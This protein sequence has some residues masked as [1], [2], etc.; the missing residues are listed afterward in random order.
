MTLFEYWQL[1]EANTYLKKG[2]GIFSK[3]CSGFLKS[4]LKNNMPMAEMPLRK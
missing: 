1:R 2:K 4:Y 3:L